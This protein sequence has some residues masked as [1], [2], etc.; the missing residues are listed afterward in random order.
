[1]PGRVVE[2]EEAMQFPV[3][4]FVL[5]RRRAGCVMPR[6]A[7]AARAQLFVDQVFGPDRQK[8]AREAHVYIWKPKCIK[9]DVP[10]IAK[11]LCRTVA[12]KSF[13]KG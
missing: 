7:F 12:P 2:T 5:L 11:S 8:Y 13:L 4:T 9:S 3:L 1:M 6:G 10:A